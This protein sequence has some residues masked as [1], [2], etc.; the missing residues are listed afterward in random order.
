[1]VSWSETLRTGVEEIDEQHQLLF[2]RAAVVRDAVLAG[3]GTGEVKAAIEFLSDYAA[4][5]FEAEARYMRL[6]AYPDQRRHL[7]DHEQLERELAAATEAWA[8]EGESTALAMEVAELIEQWLAGHIHEHD[9]L[10]ATWLTR[11][12]PRVG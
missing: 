4:V 8:T 9:R 12:G 2:R 5:H 10:L 3:R 11:A 1:M 6:A 7:A